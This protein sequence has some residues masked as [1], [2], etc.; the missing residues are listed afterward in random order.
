MTE[1][2][3]ET[4]QHIILPFDQEEPKKGVILETGIESNYKSVSNE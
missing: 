2:E 1:Y 3:N 4:T